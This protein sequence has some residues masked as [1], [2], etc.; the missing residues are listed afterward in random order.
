MGI[1]NIHEYSETGVMA[2]L[3]ESGKAYATS[4]LAELFHVS[5]ASMQGTINLLIGRGLVV[6][7]VH[8]KRRRYMLARP[9]VEDETKP[10]EMKPYL[11][12]KEWATVNDRIKELRVHA[13]K[14]FD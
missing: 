10:Y 9:K 12:G 3:K 11:Q 8:G 1:K 4:E 14:F 5:T 13:S 2:R 6:S 7:A